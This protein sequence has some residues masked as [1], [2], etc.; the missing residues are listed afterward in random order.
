MPRMTS[1]QLKEARLRKREEEER[2]RVEE[3]E[4]LRA[5]KQKKLEEQAA[6]EA[7]LVP[8][9]ERLAYLQQNSQRTAQ[10][11]SVLLGL[12]EE[13]DKLAKRAPA[14]QITELALKRTNDVIKKCKDLMKGDEF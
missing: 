13:I 3:E 14:D 5:E 2:L 1:E 10:L 9:R 6:R 7:A 12:Y 11:K 8:L 4:R